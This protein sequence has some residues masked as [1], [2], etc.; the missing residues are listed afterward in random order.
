[1]E[2][3]APWHE[4]RNDFKIATPPRLKQGLVAV[5]G[6]DDVES[7]FRNPSIAWFKLSADRKGFKL[8][9]TWIEGLVEG[10]CERTR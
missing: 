8:F 2:V 4:I 6:T 9:S 7:D 5:A 3:R 10:T 1:M